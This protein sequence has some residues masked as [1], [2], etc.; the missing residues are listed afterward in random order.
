MSP[1]PTAIAASIPAVLDKI[2]HQKSL[3]Q[4]AADLDTHN[5]NASSDWALRFMQMSR[6]K[7]GPEAFR[8]FLLECIERTTPGSRRQRE[9]T[10][11][12]TNPGAW[13]NKQTLIWLR[14]RG[15]AAPA[16]R[17]FPR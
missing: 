5:P 9:Y 15:A 14:R 6:F 10:D 11:T 3:A 17:R 8:Q 16:K 1:Q 4:Q 13:M 12:I 2:I 7:D